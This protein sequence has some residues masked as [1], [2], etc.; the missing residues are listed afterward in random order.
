MCL[1]HE[2]KVD[3]RAALRSGGPDAL[4]EVLDRAMRLKPL[5]HAFAIEDRAAAPA[6]VRHMSVTGG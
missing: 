3:L 6:T 1:G 5:A 4:N 2:D